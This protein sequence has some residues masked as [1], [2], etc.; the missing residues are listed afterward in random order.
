MSGRSAY[1]RKKITETNKGPPPPRGRAR[2]TTSSERDDI[3]IS[4]F[5]LPNGGKAGITGVP[6]TN[7]R[8]LKFSEPV[9]RE[10]DNSPYLNPPGSSSNSQS[11]GS[12]DGAGSH[13]RYGDNNSGHGTQSSS[14]G[15]LDEF[16]YAR[17]RR[18]AIRMEDVSGIEKS[19]FRS[20]ID[21]KSEEMRKGLA[22]TFTFGKKKKDNGKQPQVGP[23]MD[24]RP[25]SSATVRPPHGSQQ[26][27]SP[28]DE[29]DTGYGSAEVAGH[30][31]WSRDQDRHRDRDQHGGGG[32]NEQWDPVNNVVSPPPSAKLPPLPAAAQSPPIKRWCGNGK[33]V[34]RWNKLRKDPELWDPNGDV[35]VYLVHRGAQ[36]RPNAS[37]RLSSHIIEAT[38]SRYLIS[39]LREGSTEDSDAFGSG[40]PPSPVG[41]PPML[42]SRHRGDRGMPTPPISEDSSNMGMPD[43]DGQISYEMYF[44][45]PA[46][47]TKMDQVRY[48]ITTRNVF[49]LL[50]HASLVGLSFYQALSDLQSRLEQYLPVSTDPLGN[51]LHYMTARGLDDVRNDPDS[52]SA[53]LAWSE[54]PDVRWDEGWREAF[55]HSAGMNGMRLESAPDYKHVSPVTRA[56][57]ERA[58]LETQLRV[59][60]AEERLATFD[61]ADMWKSA[62]TPSSSP[63]RSSA[64]RLQ[65]FF[66]QFY[67][68][69]YASWPPPPTSLGSSVDGPASPVSPG[70]ADEEPWLSRRIVQKLEEDFAALYDYLVNRDIVFD[71]SE[72]RSSRKWIM[73][74]RSTRGPADAD[75][76]EIP[77]TDMLVEWDNRFRFP[78]IPSPMPLVPESITPPTQPTTKTS[79]KEKN[80]AAAAAAN[81]SKLNNTLER[82]IQFAYNEATNIDALSSSTPSGAQT[83]VDEFVKFEKRD[84]TLEV[85][86]SVA[87]RGRW[88][89]I[90]GILQTLAS[91]SVDAPAVRYRDGVSYHLSFRLK[92][93][94]VPPWRH[95][96][97]QPGKDDMLE[98]AH[99]L[100]HCWTVPASWDAGAGETDDS[101]MYDRGYGSSNYGHN[102]LSRVNSSARASQASSGGGYFNARGYTSPRGG[103]GGGGRSVPMSVLSGSVVSSTYSESDT[104][105]SIRTPS[106]PFSVRGRSRDGRLSSL[107]QQQQQQQHHHQQYYQHHPGKGGYGIAVGGPPV[108][109]EEEWSV[110]EPNEQ[111][112][113]NGPSRR[114]QQHLQLN[115]GIGMGMGSD[116]YPSRVSS[117][118]ESM[119]TGA[120]AGAPPRHLPAKQ[121]SHQEPMNDT[122]LLI[123][124][125]DELDVIDDHEP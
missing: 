51:I 39:M 72:T 75:T 55:C 38:E 11:G 69:T 74:Y 42:G 59:Q 62:L 85:D 15:P 90:Y 100:S 112:S 28:I 79:K 16:A 10:A 80:N 121:Q 68:R 103:G 64:D 34:Q 54:S 102:N 96:M 77:L 40:L 86:P 70:A 108:R 56:L 117:R 37:F 123:R 92:G 63:A 118:R 113:G 87:R 7:A 111:S 125:F 110:S 1:V 119:V 53:L 120:P 44:P 84:K 18:P 19:G 5:P 83:L 21:R 116:D 45:P 81:T 8:F 48:H 33:P 95:H 57:L 6:T 122:G 99:E 76:P 73:I 98:A 66:K 32:F 27:F 3:T 71:G 50:Y 25:E 22:K 105:S 4:D 91:V 23:G 24:F 17:A 124:D 13:K 97:K 46:N 101:D 30:H 35:L 89:L 107:Q 114:Q 14:S 49:A 12:T 88:V 106:T 115:M 41:A 65:L 109:V 9:L 20:A 60:A 2:S 29:Y 43:Q 31:Q 47:M 58:T 61:Y 94:R 78:H 104:A 26:A 67:S 93:Q 82:R 36:P 52:A